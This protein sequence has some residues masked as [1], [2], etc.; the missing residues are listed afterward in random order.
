MEIR[1]RLLGDEWRRACWGR[2][3]SRRIERIRYTLG[4]EP[5]G[6]KRGSS[7]TEMLG[8]EWIRLEVQLLWEYLW[9]ALRIELCTVLTSSLTSWS[10]HPHLFISLLSAD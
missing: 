1:L 3:T 9:L 7:W 10:F 4:K 6:L 2:K 5:R 8:Q